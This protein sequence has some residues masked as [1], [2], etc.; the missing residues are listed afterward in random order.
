MMVDTQLPLK[1]STVSKCSEYPRYQSIS[2]I[3]SCLDMQCCDST[4]IHTFTHRYFPINIF[5]TLFYI[6]RFIVYRTFSQTSFNS[7]SLYVRSALELM[8]KLLLKIFLVSQF[9]HHFSSQR[10]D[11]I[12]RIDKKRVVV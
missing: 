11:S 8:N 1:G 10:V 5:R 9:M 3:C 6:F 4:R 2:T 12:K 7:L